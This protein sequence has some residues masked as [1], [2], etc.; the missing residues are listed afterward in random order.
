MEMSKIIGINQ[1]GKLV[2]MEESEV[3]Q[4]GTFVEIVNRMFEMYYQ[5]DRE[6]TSILKLL[7]LLVKQSKLIGIEKFSEGRKKI[8]EER[9]RDL[10]LGNIHILQGVKEKKT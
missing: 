5:T 1:W 3:A 6:K 2:N 8:D 4:D 7:K 9:A 10:T